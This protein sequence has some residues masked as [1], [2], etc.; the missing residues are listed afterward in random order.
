M[1]EFAEESLEKL[2]PAFEVI[3]SSKLFSSSQFNNFV[4]QCSRYE[5]RLQKRTKMAMDYELYINH[6]IDFI[7][8]WKQLLVE[9]KRK[10]P[11]DVVQKKF[12]RKISWLYKI[13]SERFKKLEYYL[14][15]ARFARK[16]NM[17]SAA[18]NAYN[19]LLQIHAADPVHYFEVAQFELRKNKN[20]DN[21]RTTLLYG[22]RHFPDDPNLMKLLNQVTG[23][24]LDEV[25][26]ESKVDD[27]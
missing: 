5:Y 14:E 26:D 20:V 27:E 12:K 22:L 6:L 11:N 17:L 1:A 13:R 2:V 15:E 24:V 16:V 10:M 18:S 25:M 9:N 3:K 4:Q 21:A 23:N 19:K 8:R 7:T